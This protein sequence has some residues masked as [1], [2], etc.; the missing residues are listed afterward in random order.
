[1]GPIGLIRLIVANTMS[2]LVPNALLADLTDKM[3]EKRGERDA[4]PCHNQ[5]EM[6]I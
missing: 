5:S 4:L 1:M 2:N 3:A 6:I